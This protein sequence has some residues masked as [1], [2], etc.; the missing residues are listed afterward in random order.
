MVSVPFG[1]CTEPSN[2]NA[3]G[4]A[5]P[6]RFQC[7]GCGFFRPDPSYLPALEDHVAKLRAYRE[8]ALAMDAAEYVIANLTAQ[9]DAF[10]GVAGQMRHQLT[11][12]STAGREEVEQ[13]SKLLRRARAARHL[14]IIGT[15]T[16]VAG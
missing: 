8:S 3:G 1:N 13:A 14:P 15:T 2:V 9:I 5:C 4:Q 6:I 12:L 11:E 16:G 10:A 7:A